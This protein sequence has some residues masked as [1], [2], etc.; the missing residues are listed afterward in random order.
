MKCSVFLRPFI[1]EDLEKINKWRNDEEIQKL[2][3]GRFRLVSHEIEKKWLIDKMS[4]NATQEYFAICLNDES[5]EMIGYTCIKDIDIYNR[6]C[7]LAGIVID[8]EYQDGTYMIDTHLLIFHYIFIH[9]GMNR[10]EGNCLESHITSRVMIES[11]GFELEGIQ[12]D[13]IYK[14]HKFHNVC[15]YALRYEIYSNLLHKNA[16]TLSN[17]AKRFRELRKKLRRSKN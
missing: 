6:K 4:N 13:S 17:I 10:I 9:L 5:K 16:Y 14:H 7:H 12:I 15:S 3:C 11:F 2:T 1:M 8:K